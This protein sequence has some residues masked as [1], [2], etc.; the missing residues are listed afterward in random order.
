MPLFTFIMDYRGGT[1][2][3]QVNAPSLTKALRH[4]AN[5]FDQTEVKHLG[6][7]GKRALIKASAKDS[8]VPIDGTKNAWCFTAIVG[9]HL[10]LANIVK[11]AR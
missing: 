9:G 3:R 2:I 10:A 4:W 8:P 6:I 7:S 5:T 11:T 1:Y